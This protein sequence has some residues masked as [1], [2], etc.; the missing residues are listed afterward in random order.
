MGA[1]ADRPIRSALPEVRSA[2]P[3]VRGAL[4]RRTG[5][6][7]AAA[8]PIAQ[9]AL[10]A[11][12]AWA[13]ASLVNPKPFFAPISAVIS[14]G[15]ARGRR[16]TRAIELVL[17]VAVGI[18]VADV[19]VTVL[20]TGTLVVAL[21]VALTMA[22]A[23][24]LG[25]GALFVNQA[26][27]SA[28]LVATLQPPQDGLSPDRFVDALIGGG[29]ALLVGQVLFP[30]DPL[31]SMAG[32]ARPV[33]E[34]LARSLDATARALREGD[35]ERAER[36]LAIARGVDEDVAT[37]FDA[38]A[39]AR[40][41]MPVLPGRRPRERLPLYAE[42]AQRMDFAVRNTRVLCVRAV[43]AIRRGDEAPPQLADAIATLAEAVRALAEQ[44][45]RPGGELEVRRH[46]LRAAARATR[47][48]DGEPSL[49]VVVIIGQIRSAAM[50]LLR[51]SGM[52]AEEA[53]RALDAATEDDEP[54]TDVAMRTLPP[55]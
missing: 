37:F 47:L 5:R 27:V 41:T 51:G 49:S 1:V 34:E 53:R 38:V 20:G 28:I 55:R 46:A 29:V 13:L 44:L 26:A 39:L 15:A 25:A 23:L 8:L 42:A 54:P 40:E 21:V 6:V 10:A 12:L 22:V 16:T 7:R 32:A 52:G 11:S 31:R 4:A 50:D 17:G 24:L 43:A 35:R 36:A 45:A 9:T 48:M 33:A 14:L 30:R 18:A 3:E 2:L 19:I